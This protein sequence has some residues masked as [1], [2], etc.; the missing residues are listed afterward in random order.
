MESSSNREAPSAG[1]SALLSSGLGRSDERCSSIS[2]TDRFSKAT[3]FTKV[4]AKSRRSGCPSDNVLCNTTGLSESLAVCHCQC[5]SSTQKIQEDSRVEMCTRQCIC[6]RWRV[7]L[8][9]LN[10]RHYYIWSAKTLRRNDRCTGAAEHSELPRSTLEDGA[11]RGTTECVSEWFVA[12]LY[13]YCLV[14]G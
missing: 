7:S 1:S 4:D 8:T 5:H 6:A 2:L 12:S 14:S 11:S 13:D 10:T 3:M 9:V